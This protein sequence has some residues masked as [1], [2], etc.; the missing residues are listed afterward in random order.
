M[1]PTRLRWLLAVALLIGAVCLIVHLR[2]NRASMH[3][4]DLAA[5]SE[6]KAA[7]DSPDHARHIVSVE[8]QFMTLDPTGRFLVNSI[9]HK[10]VFMTGDT[11]WALIVQLDD[12]GVA[13]YLSDRASRGF[14]F[15]WAGAVDNAYQSKPPRNYY[16][17]RPFDG[18]DF[19]NEDANY[20]AHV[21]HVLQLASSCG[22]TVGITPGFAGLTNAD[23]Y[24]GSYLSSSDAVVNAYGVWLGKRYKDYPNIL[25]IL[26]GDA[27]PTDAALYEKLNQLA[28]GIRSVDS[29]HLITFEAARFREAGGAAPN[30]GWSSLDAWGSS[31]SGAH[32]AAGFSPAWLDLNWVYDPYAGTLAGCSRNYV[33]YVA[34]SPHMPQMAGEDW[35][36]GGTSVTE[37]M[38]REEAYW[39]VLSGCTL[40]RIFGNQAIWTFGGPPNNMGQTWQSQLG[41]EGSTAQQYLGQLFRSREFWKMVPDIDHKVMTAGYDPRSLFRSTWE[42]LRALA[43]REPRLLGTEFSVAARTADGQTIIAYIPKGN[44]TTITMEIDQITDAGSQAMCWWFNPRDGSSSLI[45]TL[46]T[47]GAHKFSAPDRKDWIL[48]IDSQGANLGA[49][50][51]AVL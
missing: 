35:Y 20:W 30:L 32:A 1:T 4:S 10:R 36:E 14:N 37:L 31:A 50:G 44:A 17:D 2:Q 43:H 46:S 40:G 34:S 23:G 27:D 25:W 28:M 12:A 15:L 8:G 22:I 16:G 38:L 47:R 45:G 51:S 7:L 41:S 24:R 9:T 33:S 26:G 29:V 42:S 48:V 11:A 3:G 39:E 18:A 21:D 49:P 5:L 13:T 19:T 6:G